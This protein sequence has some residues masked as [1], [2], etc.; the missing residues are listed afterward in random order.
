M[1]PENV[2]GSPPPLPDPATYDWI[3][4]DCFNT[5]IADRDESGEALG[6][7]GVWPAAVSMGLA[8]SVEELAERYR[9]WRLTR[10]QA[11]D[12]WREADLEER[13]R[14]VFG[15]DLDRPGA[16]VRLQEVWRHGFPRQ[17]G[18]I[19]GVPAMLAYWKARKRLGVVSNFYVPGYPHELLERRSLLPYLTFVIDSAALGVRKPDPRI[20]AAALDRAGIEDPARVLFV[21]DNWRNDVEGPRNV[22]LQVLRFGADQ[23]ERPAG[24]EA[25]A[26]LRQWDDFR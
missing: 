13:L 18:P 23:G 2:S 14:G 8:P 21:G 1:S 3:I 20:Y 19:A 5:L 12:T 16:L 6:F 9:A 10:R 26:T 25:V 4:F 22:G 11:A 17:T 7:C 15:A 24:T